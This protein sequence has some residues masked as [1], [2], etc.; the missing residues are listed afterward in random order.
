MKKYIKPEVE[1]L[2]VTVEGMIALSLQQGEADSSL[3]VLT[4]EE[5]EW[6]IWQ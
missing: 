1:I 3:E 4:T 5:R 2:R 6:D